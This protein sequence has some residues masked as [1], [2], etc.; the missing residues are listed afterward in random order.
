MKPPAITGAR[1]ASA[2]LGRR[3]IKDGRDMEAFCS[4]WVS[5]EVVII[6]AIQ[7]GI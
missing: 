3:S 1:T 2:R 5:F 7:G 6:W 4:A